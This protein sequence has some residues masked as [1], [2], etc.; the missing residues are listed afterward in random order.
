MGITFDFNGF[1]VEVY[2]ISAHPFLVT[3]RVFRGECSTKQVYEE[4]ARE[5]AFSVVS[6]INCKHIILLQFDI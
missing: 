1:V 4:G 5:I 3:D 6:G 2:F